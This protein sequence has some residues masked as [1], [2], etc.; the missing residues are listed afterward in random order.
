MLGSRG[1]SAEPRYLSS[2]TGGTFISR[3]VSKNLLI[4]Q[5]TSARSLSW[6]LREQLTACHIAE[7]LTGLLQIDILCHKLYGSA[8][9]PVLSQVCDA[10]AGFALLRHCYWVYQLSATSVGRSRRG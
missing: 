8:V 10:T 2:A 9:P 7:I 5:T 1:G 6:H 4:T 3:D